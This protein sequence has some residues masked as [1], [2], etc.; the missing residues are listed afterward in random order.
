MDLD[1]FYL[2]SPSLP[3]PPVCLFLFCL[4]SRSLLSFRS[5][6]LSFRGPGM[7]SSALLAWRRRHM[8]RV[9]GL[10]A[11]PWFWV[12]VWSPWPR[13]GTERHHRVIAQNNSSHPSPPPSAP[14]SVPPPLFHKGGQSPPLPLGRSLPPSASRTTPSG[15]DSRV[16]AGGEEDEISPFC[17]PQMEG[18]E[19]GAISYDLSVFTCVLGEEEEEEEGEEEGEGARG[20]C[21]KRLGTLGTAY[22]HTQVHVRAH[23]LRHSF[24]CFY[25]CRFVFIRCCRLWPFCACVR[26]RACVCIGL[27]EPCGLINGH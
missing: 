24:L 3:S 27:C 1:A 4:S 12:M 14:Q 7:R 22:L 15:K 23:I 26:A 19:T 20:E 11:S 5:L 16:R 8:A 6:P 9:R 13:D 18:G 21:N 2:F 25:F 10:V 17:H